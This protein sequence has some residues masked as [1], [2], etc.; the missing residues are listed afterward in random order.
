[1]PCDKKRYRGLHR[2]HRWFFGR[3]GRISA[4]PL[5]G[6]GLMAHHHPRAPRGKQGHP[7]PWPA[8][9]SG[10]RQLLV[11]R[12]SCR[13]TAGSG[14]IG[15]V[16]EGDGGMAGRR[17]VGRWGRQFG[18]LQSSRDIYHFRLILETGRWALGGAASRGPCPQCGESVKLQLLFTTLRVLAS[19]SASSL[20]SVKFDVMSIQEI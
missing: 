5:C 6:I 8:P 1:M 4:D 2:R 10:S 16:A 20:S 3:L 9:V 7:L 15:H 17:D 19:A 13:Q 18:R 12:S 11:E 14:I